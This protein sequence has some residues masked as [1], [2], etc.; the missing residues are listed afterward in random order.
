M[1]TLK[2]YSPFQ[3]ALSLREA[4]NQLFSQSFIQPGWGVNAT[5]SLAAPLDV[6]ETEQGFQMRVLLPGMKPEDIELSVQNDSLTVKGQFRPYM[7]HEKQARWLVQ[8]IGLGSFERT[9]TFPR[10]IDGDKIE[11]S[12]ENGVLYVWAPISEA[13][14]PKRISVSSSQ[15]LNQ[16]VDA[17]T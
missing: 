7:E 5:G 12:Y 15:P 8:E 9:I 3:E 4:M 1:T 2:I 11:T 17:A 16:T 6:L 13:G 10:P 14:R